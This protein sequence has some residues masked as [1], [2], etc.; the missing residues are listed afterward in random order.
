MASTTPQ[1]I[2]SLDRGLQILE[3]V[4][5]QDEPVRLADLAKLLGIE[6]SSAHR[7]AAT[8]LDRSFLSQDPD[9]S[10]Y[11]LSDR[12]FT[13]AGKLASQRGLQQHARKYLRQLARETGETAHLAVPTSEGATF[14]DHELGPHPIGVTTRCGQSE[15]YHCTAIG[16][17]LMAGMERDEMRD[18][19]GPVRLKA[20]T[21]NT[22]TR[23][24]DLVK[25]CATIAEEGL[26]YDREEYRTGMLCMAAPIYDFRDRV[27]A[28]LGVS[29]PANRAPADAQAPIATAVRDCARTLSAEMGNRSTQRGTRP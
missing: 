20:F 23:I 22:L 21:E 26:A 27:I 1:R 24:D 14:L 18:I 25:E 17:A 8:L 10:G 2:Q 15:P 3:Y 13:L 29:A 5:D 4:A 16:K 11:T 7:L 19:I 6:K 28:A 12:V 9:T